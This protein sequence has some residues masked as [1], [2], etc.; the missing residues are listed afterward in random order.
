MK[1]KN[2]SNSHF[3]FH[4]CSHLIAFD[5]W[6]VHRSLCRRSRSQR[7]RNFIPK[8]IQ[9][10]KIYAFFLMQSSFTSTSIWYRLGVKSVKLEWRQAVSMLSR[11]LPLWM[12]ENLCKTIRRYVDNNESVEGTLL[13]FIDHKI[14]SQQLS[15]MKNEDSNDVLCSA[16]NLMNANI[17]LL[18]LTQSRG[19]RCP[20]KPF[21]TM[22]IICKCSL[23]PEL[24][25]QFLILSS[26]SECCLSTNTAPF[27]AQLCE[28]RM[29]APL[30]PSSIVC[31]ILW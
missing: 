20:E 3:T 23:L 10:H 1:C 2:N 27:Y 13:T 19:R 15:H 30:V 21:F 25:P 7:Q 8:K 26:R 4:S 28:Q 29:H 6:R 24:D 18:I 12:I 5:D 9:L 11:M 16:L 31:C 14:H 22:C 17:A